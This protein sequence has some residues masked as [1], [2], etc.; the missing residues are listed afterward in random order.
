MQMCM[1]K[2]RRAIPFLFQQPCARKNRAPPRRRGQRSAIY[3]KKT[4]RDPQIPCSKREYATFRRNLHP[5][6]VIRMG[7]RRARSVHRPSPRRMCRMDRPFP[8]RT[9]RVH[10]PNPQRTRCTDRLSPCRTHRVRRPNPR[11]TCCADRPPPRRTHRVRR[12]NPQRTRQRHGQLSKQKC[13]VR[14]QHFR[15]KRRVRRPRPRRMHHMNRL[16][17]THLRN[18]CVRRCVHCNVAKIN[19]ICGCARKEWAR[20]R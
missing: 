6:P 11:R 15:Q 1:R 8:R 7:K 4:C 3:R 12:P 14:R 16:S 10:R 19:F 2:K 9:H 17:A 5:H 18:W 13:R 20:W